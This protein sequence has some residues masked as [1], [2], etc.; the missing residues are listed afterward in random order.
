[1]PLTRKKSTYKKKTYKR[2]KTYKPRAKK[3]YSRKMPSKFSATPFPNYAIVKMPYT[4]TISLSESATVGVVGAIK[5][6]ALNNLYAPAV[7]GGHQPLYH[8]QMSA[9]YKKYKVLQ[10]HL[11]MTIFDPTHD[12]TEVLVRILDPAMITTTMAGG[13]VNQEQ[14]KPWTY[15]YQV[16]NTGNQ[17]VV[18]NFSFNIGRVCGYTPL[19]FKAEP[20]DFSAAFN[21]ATSG[22]PAK[23]PLI[24]FAAANTRDTSGS[25]AV[26]LEFIYTV[27][28]YE[29]LNISAS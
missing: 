6:F 10:T 17:K 21:D 2:K 18:R 26:K 4:Q 16:N 1:M 24:Q 12:G 11:K 14:E 22:I 20:T 19:Q 25:V 29:R 8:D 5:N 23:G 27:L 13:D 7:S 28:V 3:N 15:S 9:I